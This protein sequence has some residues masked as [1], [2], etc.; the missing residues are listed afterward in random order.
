MEG[1]KSEVTENL[2]DALVKSLEQKFHTS[3]VIQYAFRV[4]SSYRWG[5][6]ESLGK[7][8]VIKLVLYPQLSS[9]KNSY[10]LV[11]ALS[12]EHTRA[13]FSILKG[14][15]AP[16]WPRKSAKMENSHFLS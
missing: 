13:G 5:Q 2:G 9:L 16:P 4:F 10:T 14:G 8:V 3:R 1:L 11:W 7:I 15:V 12:S 6:F